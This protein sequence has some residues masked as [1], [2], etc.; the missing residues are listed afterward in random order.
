MIEGPPLVAVTTEQVPPL[1]LVEPAPSE[2]EGL[3]S[4]R[5]D[6]IFSRV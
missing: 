6:A 5:D 2:V 4:G 1:R 3:C